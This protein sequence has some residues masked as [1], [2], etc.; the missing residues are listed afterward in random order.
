MLRFEID[1]ALF[2]GVD[3]WRHLIVADPQGQMALAFFAAYEKH[4]TGGIVKHRKG[5]R[6]AIGLHGLDPISKHQ[7]FI[8]LEGIRPREQ[9]CGVSVGAKPQ[10]DQIKA[11]ELIFFE[12]EERTK[13]SLV[14]LR[15]G[16]WVFA[17]CF[18]AKD[19]LWRHWD[20]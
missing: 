19:V 16:F 8:F 12:M 20:F 2:G 14:V 6:D 13:C 5:Q 15:D 7:A 11:R 1:T 17:F 10:Q 9:R 18:D 4:V 3:A